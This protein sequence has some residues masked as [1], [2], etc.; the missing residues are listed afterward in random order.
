MTLNIGPYK[1]ISIL[2]WSYSPCCRVSNKSDEESPGAEGPGRPA[3]LRGDQEEA[4]PGVDGGLLGDR[5]RGRPHRRGERVHG[6][7][8]REFLLEYGTFKKEVALYTTVFPEVLNYDLEEKC[9]P[10][11][12]L[13]L[14]DDVIVLEDMAHRGYQMTDKFVPFDLDHCRVMMKTLAKFH[15]KSLIFEEQ[16]KRSIIEAFSDC[17][18]ETLWPLKDGRAK[19]AFDAAVKGVVS[20]I[21]LLLDLHHDDRT[22]FK[23]KLKD[24]ASDHAKKLSPSSKYKNVLCH[25]DLW[26]NNIL[27]KYDDHGKP[28]ECCLIDFQ[29]ARYNPS[30]HDIMCFLQFTTTR[31][32]REEHSEALFKEYHEAMGSALRE[33]NLDISTIFPWEEFAESV[34]ELR[35]MCMTHGV[36]NI[37]IMLLEP[38]AASKYFMEETQLLESVLYEDRTPLICGQFHEVPRYRA[39]MQDALLELRERVAR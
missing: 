37:P 14:E 38:G 6:S 15:S 35:T 20:M 21:D 4:A 11:C 16:G 26:A 2:R 12:F 28:I 24:L 17:V 10:E 19:S 31:K 39:R 34:Q 25:G 13:G 23:E 32:L 7:P 29:L 9:F 33:A 22:V 27:F 3:V 8:Q 30:A 36:L 18:Q 1:G 5:V